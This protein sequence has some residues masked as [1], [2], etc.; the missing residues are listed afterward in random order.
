MVLEIVIASE[1]SLVIGSFMA[2]H[3]REVFFIVALRQLAGCSVFL[4]Y[5]EDSVKP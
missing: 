5:V 4:P 1:I 2:I 3:G